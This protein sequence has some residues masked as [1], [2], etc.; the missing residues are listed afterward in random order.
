[1]V[2][3]QGSVNADG[4]TGS[5][6]SVSYDDEVEGLVEDLATDA[7]DPSIK[8]FTV[9]NTMVRVDENSTNF[10]GEDP[11]AAPRTPHPDGIGLHLRFRSYYFFILLGRESHQESS[12]IAPESNA[13]SFDSDKAMYI[14]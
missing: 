2:K 8:T 6:S 13:F 7:D 14:E 10:D 1:M 11:W 4:R 5:A 3:V 9:M 12:E